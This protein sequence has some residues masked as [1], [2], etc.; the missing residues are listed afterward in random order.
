[1][2]ITRSRVGEPGAAARRPPRRVTIPTGRAR[3]ETREI[4]TSVQFAPTDEQFLVP[5]VRLAQ[6]G[7]GWAFVYVSGQGTVETRFPLAVQPFV[8]TPRFAEKRLAE[9]HRELHALSLYAA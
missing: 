5:A 7:I 8:K 3:L 2:P 9:F 4:L 6:F 1:M